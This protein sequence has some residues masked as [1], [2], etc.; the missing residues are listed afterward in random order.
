MLEWALTYF[1]HG[2]QVMPCHNKKPSLDTWEYLQ[3]FRIKEDTIV[4]WWTEWPEAQI[5]V[6]CGRI[7]GITVVDIDWVKNE[8]KEILYDQSIKPEVIAERIKDAPVSKTG[9]LGRHVFLRNFD[10]MNSTKEIHRQIDIKSDGGYII[11]P[12]SIHENGNRYEWVNQWDMVLP[13]APESL[14]K[15]CKEVKSLPKDWERVLAGVGVG[16]RNVDGAKVAGSLIRAFRK[17]IGTAWTIFLLWN[18]GNSPPMEEEELKS[19]FNSIFKKD[20]ATNSRF[21]RTNA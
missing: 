2:W 1:R 8:A 4:K 16:K 11:L 20:Y 14:K 21:Y 13:E 5:A 7:S 15:A 3:D 9:S 6:V 12:P 18:K 17:D 10:A 19:I